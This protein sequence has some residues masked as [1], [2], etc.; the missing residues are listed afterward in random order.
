MPAPAYLSKRERRLLDLAVKTAVS[1]TPRAEGVYDRLTE[2]GYIVDGRATE[3]GR[4][5]LRNPQDTIDDSSDNTTNTGNLRGGLDTNHK[6][7]YQ[8]GN[9]GH[10]TRR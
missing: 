2:Y 6:G 1:R 3:A 10:G 9:R 8:S 4:Q 7:K 5:A